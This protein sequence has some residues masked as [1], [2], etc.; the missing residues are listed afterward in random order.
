MSG[1][2]KQ[3]H[4]ARRTGIR[5]ATKMKEMLDQNIRPMVKDECLKEF[6]ECVVGLADLIDDLKKPNSMKDW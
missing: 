5:I 3:R 2:S 6:D 4:K 1:N